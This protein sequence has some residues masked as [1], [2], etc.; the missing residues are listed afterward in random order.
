LGR[1]AVIALGARAKGADGLTDGVEA[2]LKRLATALELE[3]ND[4]HF[5]LR[6]GLIRPALR[7]SFARHKIATSD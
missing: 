1:D 5:F 3:D 2:L 6:S 4:C 7:F